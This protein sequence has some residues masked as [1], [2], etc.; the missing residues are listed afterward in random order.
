MTVRIV[1]DSTSDLTPE[2]AKKWGITIVPLTVFFGDESYLDNVDLDYIGFYKKLQEAKELPQTSQPSPARY[3]ET[4]KRLID[5]GATGIISAHLSSGLSG[6]YQAA[7]NAA[8]DLPEEYRHVPIEVIDSKSASVG[9]ALPLL[10]AVEEIKQG[11]SLAEIKENLIDRYSRTH[12]IAILDTLDYLK[13]GGR[14]GGAKALLANMLSVKPIIALKDGTVIPLEQPRTRSKAFTRGVQILK[15]NE[16]LE[17]AAIV[18]A[19]PEIGSQ[20]EEVYK[21]SFTQPIQRFG[22]GSALG[23]HTGPN[24]VGIVYITAK[25]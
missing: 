13:R 25:K 15:D 5:E 1:T 21:T 3:Q 7:V 22:L 24:T 10:K 18:Q 14:I 2:L 20:L 6:T 12:I 11:A 17:E 4:Y 8:S 23:T 9:I 16:P 19:S